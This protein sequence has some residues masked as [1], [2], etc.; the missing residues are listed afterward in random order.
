MSNKPETTVKAAASTATTKPE[1]APVQP[2]DKPV[3]QPIARMSVAEL[4]ATLDKF[5]ADI[6]AR[7]N[8]TLEQMA[9][10]TPFNPA[11]VRDIAKVEAKK[12]RL[13]TTRFA[14][15]LKKG[16]PEAKA[17]VERLIAIEL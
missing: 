12:N 5:D 11:M 16:H 13:L 10:G 1:P 4:K 17:I 2:A 9:P 15:M 6:K 3:R 8:T 14:A 7:V